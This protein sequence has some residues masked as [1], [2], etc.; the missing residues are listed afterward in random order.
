MKIILQ[1]NV[2]NLGQSGDIIR[3]KPGYAR[4]YLIPRGLAIIADERNVAQL[5]H[6]QHM[7]QIKFQKEQ[8]AALAISEKISAYPLEFV[9]EAGDD[10]RLFG[11]VTNRDIAEALEAQG[12][13]V[14]RRKIK[15]S[16]TIKALGSY[17]VEV[18]LGCSVI[19]TVALTVK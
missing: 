1:S 5:K 6:I 4:N 18:D 13:T 8:K 2:S 9:R 3:V 12:V 7:A 10:G 16:D 11:S 15:I 19:A 14:D 17:S